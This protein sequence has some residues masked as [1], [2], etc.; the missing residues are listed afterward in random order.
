MGGKQHT[1][2]HKRTV[3]VPGTNRNYTGLP[4][5]VDVPFQA[6]C[7]PEYRH[8]PGGVIH[9]ACKPPKPGCTLDSALTGLSDQVK[10]QALQ[11]HN[12]YRSQVAKGQLQKYPKAKNMY[13]LVSADLPRFDV[14]C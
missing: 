8:L 4:D 7:R 14:K 12:D 11:V 3:S 6:R 5:V 9:T 1:V 2:R 10:R 13:E